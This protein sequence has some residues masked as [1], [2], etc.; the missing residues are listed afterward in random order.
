MK[1]LLFSLLLWPFFGLAQQD[2]VIT[3]KG[4]T[5]TGKVIRGNLRKSS[6]TLENA[7]GKQKIHL[8]NIREWKSGNMPVIVVPHTKG[9]RTYWYEL[10]LEVDGKKRLFRDMEYVWGQWI[11]YTEHHGKYIQLTRQSIDNQLIPELSNCPDFVERYGQQT[12]RQSD[13]EAVFSYYN[14]HCAGIAP[15]QHQPKKH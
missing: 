10:L 5:L 11:Y 12:I 3:N 8:Q 6:V 1:T 2:Y 15:A 13:L 7:D 14:Q 4:D 9:K